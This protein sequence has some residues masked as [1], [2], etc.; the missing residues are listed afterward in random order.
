M[1]FNNLKL[2]SYLK[3]IIFISSIFYFI[4]FIFENL[5]F[6]LDLQKIKLDFIFLV[7]IL[8]ILN[9]LFLSNIN[10]RILNNLK[11]NLNFM[12]SFEITI[13]NTLGNLSSPLKL[14]S[15]YKITYLK[16][17]Y[18]L[19]IKNYILLNTFFSILNLIPIFLIFILYNIFNSQ[20]RDFKIV[21]IVTI[22]SFL[23]TLFLIVFQNFQF[24]KTL[25]IFSKNNLHIHVNNI[26]FFLSNTFI[27]YIIAN[28]LLPYSSFFS[29]LAFTSLGF[30][31]NLVNL[32]PGN[33]GIKE[34]VLFIFE[35]I[36]GYSLYLLIFISFLERFISFLTL[37]SIQFCLK[38]FPI[39]K[40][41]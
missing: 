10:L 11:I 33:I 13:K 24:L 16:E 8:K 41:K 19:E 39:D 34:S 2:L 32:T 14:G 27:V 25:K 17:H 22:I 3:V 18:K 1:K 4:Y 36:H 12:E 9:I 30:V 29:A 40:L 26:L 31:V 37:F 21:G 23:V 20:V 15:G 6:F 35:N 38:Y 28:Q 7:L 5:Q